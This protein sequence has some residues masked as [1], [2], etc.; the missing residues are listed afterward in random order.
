M[1]VLRASS[2]GSFFCQISSFDDRPTLTR[3]DEVD[4]ASLSKNY[5]PSFLENGLCSDPVEPLYC[6]TAEPNFQVVHFT[7]IS[8]RYSQYYRG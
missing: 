8:Q 2:T 7:M 3:P 4:F 5:L 1:H 6:V